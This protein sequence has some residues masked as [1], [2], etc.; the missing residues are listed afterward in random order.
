MQLG[1]EL[2]AGFIS[3][4]AQAATEVES[5]L[6]PEAPAARAPAEPAAAEPATTEPATTEPAAAG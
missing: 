5:D 4:D 1:K 2:A 3:D 6:T